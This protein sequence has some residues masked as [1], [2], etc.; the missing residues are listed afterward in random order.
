MRKKTVKML[1]LS[2]AIGLAAAS[3]A[4]CGTDKINGSETALVINGEEIQLGEANFML[5]YQ[6][7][8]TY[9][10]M[11]M[12]GMSTGSLWSS[13]YDDDTTYGEYFKNNIYNS[14][15]QLVA[16]KQKAVD[17]Y[18]ITLTEEEESEITEAAE[19]FMEANPE[20]EENFG[21]TL[22]Q[23]EDVL[24]MYTYSNDLKPT[25]IQDVDTVVSDD[26]A[27]QSRILY[28]RI[29]KSTESSDS[30]DSTDSSATSTDSSTDTSSS[31]EEEETSEE[32]Q[33][34]Y[35]QMQQVQEQ[36]IADN[37]LDADAINTLAD[38]IN[39]D[40]YASEY[41]YGSD[42]SSFDETVK[43]AAESL[44]DGQ[45]YSDIIETDDYYYLVKMVAAFDE[46]ATETKKESIVSE[47][48]TDAINEYFEQWRDDAEVET[49]DCWNK[50]EINDDDIYTYKTSETSESSTDETS[51]SS[52]SS[53]SSTSSVS[54]SSASS[55]SSSASSS[56]E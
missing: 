27:A 30:T 46:E 4:G 37:S 15:V 33:E 44:E 19:S 7:S 55:E 56:Q 18:G 21:V 16:T 22:E 32:N 43:E 10:Y 6:Q 31:S 52:A 50:L 41:T 9:Y 53:V 40:F 5:R 42:D 13:N 45:W 14:I 12:M 34:L 35:A 51:A 8:M 47:R 1:S 39:E 2:L 20:A 3:F 25:L 17:E 29:K 11:Q 24:R 48:K 54:T 49:K 26:E 38:E 28:V 36:I 23:V